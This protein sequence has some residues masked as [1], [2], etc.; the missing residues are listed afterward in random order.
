M[1][2]IGDPRPLMAG[3]AILQEIYGRP[4]T[5]EDPVWMW[6]GDFGPS[7]IGARGLYP[8]GGT[9]R[10]RDSIRVGRQIDVGVVN[11]MLGAY[12]QQT[13][14]PRFRVIVSQMG[15]HIVP[16]RVRDNKG[17]WENAGSVLDVQVSVPVAKR[18]ASQHFQELCSAISAASSIR[19]EAADELLDYYYAAN[20]IIPSIGGTQQN[21]LF[22]WGVRGMNGREALI[23]LL[24]GSATTQSWQLLCRAGEKWC[25][26]NLRPIV[27]NVTGEDGVPVRKVIMFDRRKAVMAPLIRK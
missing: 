14:G 6:S 27:T 21:G 5:Y 25:A 17:Q 1:L 24:D 2:A 23:N 12:H 13:N 10:V 4:V 26:L 15:L 19:T 18:S 20:G 7:P 22:D 9:F 16:M 8:I 11:E 3:A